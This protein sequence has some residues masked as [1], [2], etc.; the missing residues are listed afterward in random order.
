M[1]TNERQYKISKT[2]LK[3]FENALASAQA[4][5]PADDLH[6]DMQDAMYAGLES[7]AD[8]LRQEIARYEKLKSGQVK[9][10][11][12]TRIRDLQEALVE[13]RIIAGMTQKQ[14]AG[15]VG[16]AEQQI[17]RYE[18]T[19]YRGVSLERLDEIGTAVGLHLKEVVYEPLDHPV[20]VATDKKGRPASGGT[21]HSG[22]KSGGR[23]AAQTSSRSG[24]HSSGSTAARTGSAGTKKRTGSGSKRSSQIG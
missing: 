6:P 23:S 9:C 4:T 7:Q 13:G 8:E 22:R 3:K 18:G 19:C 15:R 5:E 2:E 12:L 10:R 24:S 20:A 17:Q 1:I 16:L 21:N 11:P 14:L